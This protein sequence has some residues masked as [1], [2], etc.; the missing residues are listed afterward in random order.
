MP[1]FRS[2]RKVQ[3]FGTSLAMTLPAL[4]VK[5][6]EIEKGAEVSILYNLEGLL[7]VSDQRES[8]ALRTRLLSLLE[9]LEEKPEQGG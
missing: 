4:F 1:V 5:A 9:K 6:C 3:L 7:V 8:A 2:S